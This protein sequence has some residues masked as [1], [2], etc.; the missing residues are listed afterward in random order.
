MRYWRDDAKQGRTMSWSFSQRVGSLHK[1][2]VPYLPGLQWPTLPLQTPSKETKKHI[3]LGKRVVTL[4]H[5]SLVYLRYQLELKDS[6]LFFLQIH[7][8]GHSWTSPL[9]FGR[10]EMLGAAWKIQ[11]ST[12]P[13]PFVSIA[14]SGIVMPTCF[15]LSQFFHEFAPKKFEHSKNKNKAV[16]MSNPSPNRLCSRKVRITSARRPR[17]AWRSSSVGLHSAYHTKQYGHGKRDASSCTKLSGSTS[18]AATKK[19]R[20]PMIPME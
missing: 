16:K 18:W 10:P 1:S 14:F 17:M 5:F 7:S 2:R 19:T 20:S 9:Q 8:A 13:S 11:K 3:A 6:K 12:K 4:I 15:F